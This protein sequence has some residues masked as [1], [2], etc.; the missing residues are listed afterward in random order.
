MADERRDLVTAPIVVVAPKPTAALSLLSELFI[1]PDEV[2]PLAPSR[3]P[4]PPPLSEPSSG[5]ACWAAPLPPARPLPRPYPVQGE[6][7]AGEATGLFSNVWQRF[8]PAR[9]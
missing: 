6:W 7:E 1:P 5:R 9:Y 3:P 4:S 8:P 2:Q